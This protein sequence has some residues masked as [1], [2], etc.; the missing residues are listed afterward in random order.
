[1]N[2]PNVWMSVSDLMTGLMVI[3]LFISLAYIKRVQNN[4]TILKDFVENKQEL[5]KK[6]L[7][8][9]KEELGD[10]TISIG[11]DL[12][13]RFQKAESL[14]ED[15]SWE[16]KPQFKQSLSI[17]LPKYLDVLLN[18]SL[19]FKI[20]EIRIEGH[21]NNVPYPQIDRDPYMANLILS[22]RRARSVMRF[23]R[24]LPQYQSYSDS[25]KRLLEYWFTANGLSY[26]HALD[27]NNTF[28]LQTGKMIDKEKSRRVEIR[29]I[30]S[31]EEIL[32]HFVES[33]N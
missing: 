31:G 2:R 18:D 14:F 19:K 17:I 8:E 30:T 24:N 15:G 28:A 4:K 13:M 10:G 16:L 11:G 21:T 29:I 5:H 3:F 33:T 27:A 22:Q 9:F 7:D 32:E 20:R 6:L 25:D 26:G 12:S 1:M 23:L